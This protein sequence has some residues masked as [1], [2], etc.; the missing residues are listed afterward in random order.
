[1]AKAAK[2]EWL[3]IAMTGIFERQKRREDER[4]IVAVEQRAI[5]YKRLLARAQKDLEDL[6]R[7]RRNS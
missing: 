1:M 2:Q 3:R 7:C 4:R 6:R 5:R